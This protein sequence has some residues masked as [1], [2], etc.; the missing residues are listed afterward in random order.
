MRKRCA[1]FGGRTVTG[2][3]APAW[4]VLLA[5][6]GDTIGPPTPAGPRVDYVDGA[7]EPILVRGQAAVIEGFGF[8]AAPATGG[9]TLAAAGGSVAAPVASSSDW[10]DLAIRIIVPDS[11]VSGT[12]TVTTAAG[13]RLTTT[14][15]V[16]PRLRFGPDTLSWRQRTAF[17][18][19]PVG[20]GVTAAEIPAGTVVSTALYAAGGAELVGGRLVPDAGVYVARAL[21]GGAVGAWV[22]QPDNAD[23]LKSRVLPAP[24]GFAAVAVATRYNSHF[25]GSALYVIGGIDSAGRAQPSVLAADVTPDSVVGRFAPI[26]PLPAPVVGATAVVR[27]G[28]IYVIGGTDSLG[29]PQR[30]VFVGRIAAAGHIDGWYRQPLLP[31]PRAYGGGVVLDDRAVAFGGVADS[32]PPGGGLDPA[33][34]RLGSSDT[35]PVSLV[36]G[37]LAGPWASGITLF[38]APRSQFA[39]LDLG[40]FVLLVGG[41]YGGA[42]TNDAET[43]AAVVVGDSLGPFTGPVGSSTIAAQGGGTLVGPAGVTWRESDGSRHALV[44]GGIDLNTG[45]RKSGVWGF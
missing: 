6:C 3:L 2:R 5:A 7:I 20:V 26:E 27:R 43:L 19:A 9:V 18:S 37:F 8:G 34:T 39:T 25:A 10:S 16:I 28:R 17:P 15:H 41:M 44:I 38:P 33:T 40:D 29:R 35:A 21:A 11:A 4:A 23:P 32:V 30:S 45:L 13:L 12:L 22:R 14:V 42:A 1:S 36:S 31:T 24:R